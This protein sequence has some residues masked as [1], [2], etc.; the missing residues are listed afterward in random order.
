M[1]GRNIP[2]INEVKYLSVIFDTEIIWRYHTE[3]IK[4]K[5]FRKFS[6]AYSLF[7][8]DGLSVTLDKAKPNTGNIKGLNLAVVKHTAVQMSNCCHSKCY[9]S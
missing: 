2:V 1:K 5:A 7:K 6:R 4:A 3:M 9:A 8:S